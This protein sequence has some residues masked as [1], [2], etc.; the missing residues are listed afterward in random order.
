MHTIAVSKDLAT[1]LEEIEIAAWMDWYKA[2]PPRWAE[3]HGLQ[4]RKIGPMAVSIVR[5]VDILGLN[6]VI[7]FGLPGSEDRPLVKA[8]LDMFLRARVPRFFVQLAGPTATPGARSL[9]ESHGLTWYNNWVKL[10]R[11]CSPPPPVTTDL[12]I[13]KVGRDHGLK[14]G[15]V[16]TTA[17]GW[18]EHL[19]EWIAE[20]LGRPGWQH[21]AAF[22]GE[23]LVATAATFVKGKTAWFDMAATL[24]T[25]QGRGAQSAL[26]ARRIIDAG[27]A[28]VEQIAVE[29][30]EQ[31]ED[32]SAP[33][34][35]NTQ[36]FGFRI[37]YVRPNFIWKRQ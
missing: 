34:Y 35:R 9:L 16:V 33:S 8:A 31:T 17:F 13:R 25:H 12:V 30:A 36:R 15:K 27:A 18:D 28:G 5:D 10:F 4:S 11:D 1:G 20:T 23:Q 21:Y 26:L 24:P 37:G 19:A 2:A 29:T 14:F 7:G 22:D 32:K 6:R 3:K